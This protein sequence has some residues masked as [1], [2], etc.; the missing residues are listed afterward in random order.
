MT[1]AY[2][3]TAA[4]L[5]A[6]RRD[7]G[8]AAP[9]AE[10]AFGPMFC[11]QPAVTVWVWEHDMRATDLLPLCGEHLIELIGL[12]LDPPRFIHLSDLMGEPQ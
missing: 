1:A 9:V 7:P 3:P 5:D 10:F 8:C 11:G 6:I 2:H 4:E 12:V